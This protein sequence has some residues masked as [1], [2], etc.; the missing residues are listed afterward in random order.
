MSNLTIGIT[1]FNHMSLNNPQQE[2][3][4]VPQDTSYSIE[5]VLLSLN[6]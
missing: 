5:D 1:Y 2:A 3:N 4:N 6:T